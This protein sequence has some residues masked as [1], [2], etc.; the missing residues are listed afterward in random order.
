MDA[1]TSLQHRDRDR[2]GQDAGTVGQYGDDSRDNQGTERASAAGGYGPPACEHFSRYSWAWGLRE[3]LRDRLA[4]LQAEDLHEG[5]VLDDRRVW[6]SLRRSGGRRGPPE[7]REG[8]LRQGAGPVRR[9]GGLLPRDGGRRRGAARGAEERCRLEGVHC[10]M[11]SRGP[12]VC[13]GDG[14]GV[15]CVCGGVYMS[16]VV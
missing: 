14:Q 5:A 13:V 8:Q 2:C 7:G 1:F 10:G 4:E 15:W 12:K 11:R 16:M 6:R 3:R 9:H